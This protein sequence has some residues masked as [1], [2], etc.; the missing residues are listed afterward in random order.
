MAVSRAR[1][2]PPLSPDTYR[3]QFDGG[4]RGNPGV[5]GSGFVLYNASGETV[6]KASEYLGDNVTNNQAEYNGLLHGLHVADREGV[7]KLRV[8]GDSKL[9]ISQVTGAW[10]CDAPGLVPLCERAKEVVSHFE[11]CEFRHI[12]RESNS[13]AD[14]LANKAMDCRH[15]SM[16][17]V[18]VRREERGGE[19]QAEE[20]RH[21]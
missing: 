20:W 2:S 8:E 13:E 12:P 14:K 17:G 19:E 9:V 11:R 10:R 21:V 6:F 16:D 4:S 3:L 1:A 7:R 5:S 15:S 18:G